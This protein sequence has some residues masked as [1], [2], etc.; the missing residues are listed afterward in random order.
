MKSSK[1]NTKA[2]TISSESGA[3]FLQLPSLT[4]LVSLQSLSGP[5]FG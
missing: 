4:L 5:E 2:E 1:R 3:L